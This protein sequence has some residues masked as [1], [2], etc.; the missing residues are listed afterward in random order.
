MSKDEALRN[1]VV[2][3]DGG[4]GE[5]EYCGYDYALRNEP[6]AHV[7]ISTR[8]GVA[9]IFAAPTFRSPEGIGIGSSLAEV[10]SA[11]PGLQQ[12][13]NIFHTPVP[14]NANASYHFLLDQ[15]RRVRQFSLAIRGQD[16]VN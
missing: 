2:R 9:V 16:C 1:G 12:S 8:L 14:G 11:Y 15:D 4:L 13:P 7:N 5:T 10:R 3:Q 6:A